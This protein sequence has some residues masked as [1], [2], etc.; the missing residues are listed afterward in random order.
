[1]IRVAGEGTNART[2]TIA[3]RARS[4][5]TDDA[6]LVAAAKSGDDEALELLVERYG[7]MV[8]FTVLRITGNREDAEDV[9]QQSFQKAFCSLEG[10][11]GEIFLFHLVDTYRDQL[12]SYVEA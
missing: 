10:L 6:T 12:G 2:V 9:V 7:R 4:V 5:A 3:A 11:P 1:M 8:L